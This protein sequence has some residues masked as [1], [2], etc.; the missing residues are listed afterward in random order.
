[1]RI[2][3]T[4]I[5]ALF[6]AP[7]FAASALAT[8]TAVQPPA[9][10][11]TNGHKHALAAGE[12]IVAGDHL[13]TGAG[14]RVHIELAEDS[15]VKL[16]E[17][18]D[19]VVPM[20]ES[21]ALKGDPQQESQVFKAA[22][23]VLAGAFRFT[24]R[25]LG[26]PKAREVDVTIGVATAGIRGTD[27]WG[28]SDRA[29]DLIALLEGHIEVARAGDAPQ[30]MDEAGTFFVVPHGK[31][32]EPVK[33]APA[34]TVAG[35]AAQTELDADGIAMYATGTYSVTVATALTREQ[36]LSE[37]RRLS[38]RGYAAEI[39]TAAGGF[40]AVMHGFGSQAE[41]N[42]FGQGMRKVR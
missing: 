11:E 2:L 29:Q 24:T 27:I 26:K 35:W 3:V 22:L 38:D 32:P 1:M 6:A 15:I 8:A 19:F 4:L 31:A 28:K 42:R 41:A 12:V 21:V 39:A 17:S 33:P 25:A 20:L 14:A 34:K 37:V 9:W 13:T 16:G 7:G 23:K 40:A 36:A 10:I 30:K 5:A 18:A